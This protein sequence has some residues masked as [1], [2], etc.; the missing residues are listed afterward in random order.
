[1]KPPKELPISDEFASEEE[2]VESLLEYVTT[3]DMYQILCGGI[4]ILDFFTTDPGLYYT[5][6]PTE[7]QKFLKDCEK[8]A[9][10]DFLLR[11]DLD[12]TGEVGDA[13]RPPES[14]VQFVKDIRRLTLRRDF[15]PRKQ[16]LPILP[17]H[18]TL[19][20]NVK[21]IH[22][23]TNFAD[24]ADRLADGVST[25]YG[26]RVTHLI[27]FGSGQ[28]YLGRALASA[29][30]N[31]HVVAVESKGHNIASAKSLDVLSG[32]AENGKPLRNK[33]VFM[34]LLDERTPADKR[35]DKARDRAARAS[36][37]SAEAIAAVELRPRRELQ[38][39]YPAEEGKGIIHYVEGRLETGDLS[40]V[41]QKVQE[42]LPPDKDKDLRLMA[43]S[44]H[45]CGNLSHFGIRSM[46][47]N[48]SIQA[49]AIVGCCYNLMTEKLGPPTHPL[50]YMR[51]TL[52][53]L[54]RREI[55]ESE[56]CD[57]E[58]FPLSQ[59]LSTHKGGIRYNV[60]ARMMAC[61]AP[62]NWDDGG[63]LFFTRHFFRTVLQRIFFDRGVVS[64]ISHDVGAPAGEGRRETPFNTSTNP[65]VLGT[66]AKHCYASFHSYVRGAIKKLTTSKEYTEHAETVRQRM[67]GITDEEIE[68]Y[69]QDY[70][71]R[72]SEVTS[73]WSLMAFC[74]GVTE[75]AIVTD[76]WLFLKENPDVVQDCWV[77]TVFDY[78]QSPRNLVV[79]GIKK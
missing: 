20:M 1:M 45:S 5:A 69:Y 24:Y 63:E 77:E 54:N 37:L 60:S 73:V 29:P 27:D 44:I 12:S 18:V 43:V 33:K 58:G 6:I 56:R 57:P 52:Q 11:N 78:H 55:R 23:V 59:R 2:Y 76:R 15:S 4:H 47:L 70:V 74:A 50:P 49:V 41:L 36:V 34:Q 39:V 51:Q 42:E 31:R 32:L 13:G 72:R 71:D 17:R 62:A 64:K 38:V 40:D 53:S 22:E 7:W 25:A 30:Y 79:V 14:L 65:I 61:Q 46:I 48:P 21:K 75:S 3:T 35:G 26:K 28:N 19:G 67:A 66:L 68:R 9:L 10:L 16:K 8:M